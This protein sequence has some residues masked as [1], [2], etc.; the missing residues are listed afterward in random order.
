M[1]TCGGRIPPKSAKRERFQQLLRKPSS[2]CAAS[3][4]I[5]EGKGIVKRTLHFTGDCQNC[6][7]AETEEDCTQFHHLRVNN[8][9]AMTV[10]I[11]P[12]TSFSCS[13][14]FQPAKMDFYLIFISLSSFHPLQLYFYFQLHSILH[15]F[16]SQPH[17]VIALLFSNGILL[18]PSL[19]YHP[20][21]CKEPGPCYIMLL[22]GF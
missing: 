22:I 14:I 19:H 21:C 11:K 9:L 1:E 6:E 4:R 2:E 20:L 15:S 12:Q 16:L 8:S 3:H 13:F 5:R 18:A 17:T 10:A 7:L